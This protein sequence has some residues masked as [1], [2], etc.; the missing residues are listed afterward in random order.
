ML[1][2]GGLAAC[3]QQVS[4]PPVDGPVVAPSFTG[5]PS[6]PPSYVPGENAGASV[7]R[8]VADWSFNNDPGKAVTTD[9]FVVYTTER[10]SIITQRMPSFLEAALVVAQIQDG[11]VEPGTEVEVQLTPDKLKINGEKM[12][13][14]VHQKYL[15]LYEQQQGVELSGNSRVEFTTKSKQRM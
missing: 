12:P 6:A 15:K 14:S 8:S 2:A 4:Q 10:S 7:V 9:N 1:L 3:S 5:V 13:E 11:L